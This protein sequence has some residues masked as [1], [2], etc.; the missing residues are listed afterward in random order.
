MTP[1][2]AC[3]REHD[4][5]AAI[6]AGRWPHGCEAELTAHV[7]ACAACTELLPVIAL[8]RGERERL[9]AEAVVPS[10]GQVWWRAAVR[11]RVEATQTVSRPLT[12]MAGAAVACLIGLLASAVAV[13]WPAAS[14][15]ALWG[16]GWQWVREARSGVPSGGVELVLRTSG[17]LALGA[18]TCVLLAP[19]A[20]YLALSDD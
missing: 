11:A 3:G 2:E 9:Q 19:L 12:W 20:L 13:L 7:A 14:E 5:A 17:W 10:S 8:L 15:A 16:V 18:L 4:L 6:A 1:V